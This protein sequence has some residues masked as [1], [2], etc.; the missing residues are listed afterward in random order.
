MD[1]RMERGT[2]IIRWQNEKK[3]CKV[4]IATISEDDKEN[5]FLLLRK[6]RWLISNV[7]YDVPEKKDYEC[8]VGDARLLWR[9]L[10]EHHEFNWVNHECR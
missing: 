2:A 8:S 1:G 7:M 6:S 9:V 10:I 5:I 3:C 4:V